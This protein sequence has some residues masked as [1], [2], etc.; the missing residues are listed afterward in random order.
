MDKLHATQELILQS[1]MQVFIEKGRH[2]ARMQEIADRAGINKALLH[3][4]YRSKNNLY[5]TVIE[6]TFGKNISQVMK[7]LDKDLPVKEIIRSFIRDYIEILR[8]NPRLP[9]F[10]LRELSEGGEIVFSVLHRLIQREDII[11]QKALQILQQAIVKEEIVALDP[12]QLI[13]TIIGSCLFF[14]ISEPLL[15]VTILREGLTDREQFIEER[16]EAIF[17]IIAY[18][19]FPR[20]EHS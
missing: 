14:F 1:A 10:I 15:K 8:K 20:G 9:L 2:G 16:K 18:G 13:I 19:I 12:R 4:Y 3:Y 17:N 5:A 7:I 6:E 11:P